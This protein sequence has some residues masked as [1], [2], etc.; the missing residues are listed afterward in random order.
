MLLGQYGQGLKRCSL[1]VPPARAARA[2]LCALLVYLLLHLLHIETRYGLF[3]LIGIA[4]EIIDHLNW[5]PGRHLSFTLP[6]DY[7]GAS[8]GV[9]RG[10]HDLNCWKWPGARRGAPGLAD[11]RHVGSRL[12]A[13]L[14]YCSHIARECGAELLLAGATMCRYRH[15][16]L[17][18]IHYFLF[19]LIIKWLMDRALHIYY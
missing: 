14:R 17:V 19:R 13:L 6:Y 16:F 11:R 3:V 1:L 2:R 4:I 7:G 9:A 12:R 15:R 18:L 10:L 8:R 5:R